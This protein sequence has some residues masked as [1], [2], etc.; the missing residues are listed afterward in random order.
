MI[1]I[2]LK[3][4]YIV[5]IKNSIKT[6][7]INALC[8]TFFNKLKNALAFLS[9]KKSCKT[10]TFKAPIKQVTDN[11][12]TPT[13]FIYVFK[14]PLFGVKPPL[15]MPLND[16]HKESK[17]SEPENTINNTLKKV[18]KKYINATIFPIVKSFINNF[19]FSKV[20]SFDL[21]I[22]V[23]NR[24]RA[25]SITIAKVATQTPPNHCKIDRHNTITRD[26]SSVIRD[27]AP[28]VVKAETDSKYAEI[29]L[30]VV[31]R[32]I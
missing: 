25:A 3:E 10:A 15:E 23:P 20:K 5:P 24:L 22:P 19:P 28:V 32:A 2:L 14:G 4:P 17:I 12:V 26:K 13:W 8:S 18:I 21:C 11:I 29:K 30:F 6:R 31:P 27:E 16:K 7:A 9:R 1:K